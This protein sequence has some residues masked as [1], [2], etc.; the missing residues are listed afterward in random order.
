M[1]QNE[2]NEALFPAR[3]P[4][5][6]SAAASSGSLRLAGIPAAGKLGAALE[7]KKRG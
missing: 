1:E 3:S 6:A 4:K 2:M 7:Q 5:W